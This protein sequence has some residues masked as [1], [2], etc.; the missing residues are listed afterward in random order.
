MEKR[1]LA[2]LTNNPIDLS[3]NAPVETDEDTCPYALSMTVNGVVE[4]TL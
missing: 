1:Y 3:L 4:L 2:V